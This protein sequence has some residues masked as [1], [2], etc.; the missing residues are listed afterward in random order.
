MVI[1]MNRH[2]DSLSTIAVAA[3][4]FVILGAASVPVLPVPAGGATI[5]NPGSGDYIG[6]RITVSPDGRAAAVD[7]A[8]R[9]S[10]D[11]RPELVRPFFDDLAAASPSSGGRSCG[12]D[13]GLTTT[14]VQVNAAVDVSWNGRQFSK[15]DC[16][17]D[18]RSQRLLQDA[19]AIRSAL[20]VQTYRERMIVLFGSQSGSGG[21]DVSAYVPQQLAVSSG[22]FGT[23]GFT[24]D[25]FSA[26]NFQTNTFTSGTR[27]ASSAYNGSMPGSSL[28]GSLPYDNIATGLPAGSVTFTSPWSSLPGSSLA[29]DS[30]FNGSAYN[31]SPYGGGP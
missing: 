16:A 2:I 18:P 12:A 11:L 24:F 1:P 20:Y 6:F 13:A 9:A 14:T 22:S 15:L 27:V 28:T 8:G 26:G 31:G 17:T 25:H 4:A 29:S 10:A 23:G 21:P 5:Y 7:A 30:P 19:M 3:L